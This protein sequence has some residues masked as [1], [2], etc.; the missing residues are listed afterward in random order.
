MLRLVVALLTV[1]TLISPAFA[2]DVFTHVRVR[3]HSRAPKVGLA[4]V[5]RARLSAA[6]IAKQRD[7]E[8]RSGRPEVSVCKLFARCA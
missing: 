8:L 3:K 2:R 5:R 4:R 1:L 7:W 6:S